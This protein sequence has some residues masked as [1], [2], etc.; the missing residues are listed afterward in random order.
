[1][2]FIAKKGVG[3]RWDGV[4]VRRYVSIF[5]HGGQL[6]VIEVQVQLGEK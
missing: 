2:K 5:S 3:V 6:G 4:G 1:M